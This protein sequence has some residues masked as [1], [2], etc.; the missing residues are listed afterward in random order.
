MHPFKAGFKL[1]ALGKYRE[2]GIL[3]GGGLLAG[4]LLFLGWLAFSSSSEVGSLE[5]EPEA[6]AGAAQKLQA[7]GDGVLNGITGGAQSPQVRTVEA[8]SAEADAASVDGMA[9]DAGAK[10]DGAADGSTPGPA[11]ELSDGEAIANGLLGPAEP[12]AAEPAPDAEPGNGQQ[13]AVSEPAKDR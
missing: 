9:A 3:F 1:E 2:S 13:A 10:T 7:G 12:Q 4:L 6:A 11:T 5:A 8:G